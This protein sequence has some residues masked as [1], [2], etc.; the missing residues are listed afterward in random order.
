MN[1]IFLAG[2]SCFLAGILTTAHPCPFTTNLAAISLLGG[3]S[4]DRGR[5]VNITIYFIFG[6]LS[7]IL[8]LAFTLSTGILSVTFL[9]IILQQYI[10]L[11][12]GPVLIIAGML[13]ANLLNANITN[14][15]I[16]TRYIRSGKSG[17]RAL[18]LGFLIALSFCPATAAIFFGVLIPM[19]VEYQQNLLFPFLYAL[20]ASLP[21]IAVGI[22]VSGSYFPGKRNKW[23]RNFPSITGAILII[24][25]IYISISRIFSG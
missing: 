4:A 13:Q 22:M 14:N 25:G 9:S 2:G 3:M 12:M 10:N 23:R 11:F 5:S 19:A 17:F 21:V 18:P 8:L 24:T 6:Y 20:G 7:A 15:R 16:I 1:D